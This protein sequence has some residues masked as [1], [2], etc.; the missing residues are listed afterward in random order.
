[1]NGYEEARERYAAY[2]VDTEAALT[3]LNEKKISFNAWQLD[4]VKGF[5]R[6]EGGAGGG[7]MATGS[8]PGAAKNAAQLMQDA[9]EVFSLVPGKHKL[10]LQ[11][12]MI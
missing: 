11:S 4:D 2:G 12:N 6:L 5:L 10:S 3:A 7:V 8:Y 1:M 9:D